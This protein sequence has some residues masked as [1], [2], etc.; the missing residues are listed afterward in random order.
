MKNKIH[1][2]VHILETDEDFDEMWAKDIDGK[3]YDI[4]PQKIGDFEYL[5][6]TPCDNVKS[7][8]IYSQQT[9][10]VTSIAWRE[11]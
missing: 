5:F 1:H 2:E 9:G 8:G 10:L 6:N 11:K 4:D 3:T 7:I